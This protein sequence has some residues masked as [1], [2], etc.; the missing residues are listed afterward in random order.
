MKLKKHLKNYWVFYVYGLIIILGI[1]AI[2]A[3]NHYA[4]YPDNM[5]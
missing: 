2:A 1:I 5:W 3:L 4:N